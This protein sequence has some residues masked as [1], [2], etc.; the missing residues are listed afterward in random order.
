MAVLLVVL[1]LLLVV[2]V[3]AGLL[4]RSDTPGLAGRRTG[5]GGAPELVVVQ[6]RLARRLGALHAQGWESTVRVGDA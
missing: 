2:V 6:V 5:N 1:V 3:A 4:P